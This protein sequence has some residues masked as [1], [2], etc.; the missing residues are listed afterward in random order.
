ME[1]GGEAGEDRLNLP[2]QG[3]DLPE[4]TVPECAGSAIGRGEASGGIEYPDGSASPCLPPTLSLRMLYIGR[5]MPHPGSKTN[6][7]SGC[8]QVMLRSLWVALFVL[9][10]TSELLEGQSRSGKR[11]GPIETLLALRGELGLTAPQISRLEE[12]DRQMDLRN[13]PLVAR[14]REIRQR[15]RSLGPR[16]GFTPESRARYESLVADARQIMS[17]IH[18]NNRSAMAEVGEIL[19]EPQRERLAELI[20]ERK[21]ERERSGSR[22]RSRSRGI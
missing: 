20:T 14:M 9:F 16:E 3:P 2:R 15:I 13:E 8:N 22:E 1:V 7:L 6:N 18:G 11:P 10:G 5:T 4:G 19:S 12:I 21:D 17:E